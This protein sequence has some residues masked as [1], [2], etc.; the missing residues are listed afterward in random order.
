MA[1]S[2]YKKLT[3]RGL[4]ASGAVLGAGVFAGCIG[5]SGTPRAATTV[6]TAPTAV[7]AAALTSPTSAPAAVA[8]GVSSQATG[9]LRIMRGST[10]N[11]G[12]WDRAAASFKDKTGITVDQTITT[13]TVEDGTV[14]TALKSGAGPDTVIVNAGPARV[15]FLAQAGL[16]RPLND[17]YKQYGWD[18]RLVPDLW[19]RLKNQSK[20]YEFP[21]AVDVIYWDYNKDVFTKVGIQPPNTFDELTAN[22]DKLK[23]NGVYPIVLGVLSGFAGGWLFGN[24]LQAAAG[25]GAVADVLFAQGSWDQ[26]EFV[27]AAQILQDWA[28]K[29]YIPQ[30]ATTLTDQQAVPLFINKQGAMYCVG[31]WAIPTFTDGNMDLETVDTF[32]TPKISAAGSAL[33]TGGFANSWVVATNAKNPEAA[34]KWIDHVFS[35]EV[36]LDELNDPNNGTIPTVKTPA[37]AKPGRLVAK[38]ID[39]LNREGVGYNP[40]VHVAASIVQV[41]YQSLQGLLSNQVTPAQAMADVQAAKVKAAQA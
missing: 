39:V 13:G 26:P 4:L 3:R 31:T 1:G 33:P 35:D 40:S 2:T 11:A 22:F 7:G 10:G 25:K 38:A 32:V 21:G 24:L 29:E 19:D 5:P 6:P 34:Y 27:H 14:P 9:T 16:I 30:A 12:F 17:G 15:G 8:P 23:S 41:Y 20:I 37:G 36:V 18:S 28:K